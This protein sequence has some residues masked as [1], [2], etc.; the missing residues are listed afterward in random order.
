MIICS[1]D[2]GSSWV[3]SKG[4]FPAD[5]IDL[6]IAEWEKGQL[7]VITHCYGSRYCRVHESRD[8]GAVW[9]EVPG[10]IAGVWTNSQS[11]RWEKSLRVGAFVT[12][13]VGGKSV[14]L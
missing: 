2:G 5:C 7:L 14:M 12:A 9:V 6:L 10:T 3:L 11:G 8:K 1:T 4:I 13:T